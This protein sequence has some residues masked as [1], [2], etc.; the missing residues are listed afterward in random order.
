MPAPFRGIFAAALIAATTHIPA[1]EPA[2]KMHTNALAKEKSPYL[3]Q[4]A[5]NPVD[6][7]PW[8][9]ENL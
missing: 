8:G 2:S 7:L 4:H 3:L 1:A 6:W 9:P 5:H